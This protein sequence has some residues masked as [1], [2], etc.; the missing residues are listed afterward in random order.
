MPSTDALFVR[1]SSSDV[2]AVA[3]RE[4]QHT[5]VWLYGEHD[6]ATVV[7]LWE[8]LAGAIEFD[9]DKL[10]LDFSGVEF[11]DAAT[12]GV[13]ARA[14]DLLQGRS[15]SLEVR[16]VSPFAGRILASCGLADLVDPNSI[17]A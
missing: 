14:R 7:S 13:I 15:R 11:I 1:P 5:V 10:V 4:S 3:V 9:T 8:T 17:A 16:S 2:V 6:I 12:I